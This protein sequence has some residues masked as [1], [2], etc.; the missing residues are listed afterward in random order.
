MSDD[1]WRD[2]TVLLTGASSGIG[3]AA[4]LLAATRGARVGLIARRADLLVETTSRIRASGGVADWIAADVCDLALLRAV[5]AELQARLGP[6]D[7][8]IAC[9]GI[10]KHTSAR[11]FDPAIANQVFAVNV[12]GVVN[13]IG[14][15]LPD[16]VAR[17]R[18]RIAVISSLAAKLPLPGSAAYSGSKAALDRFLDC[19]RVDLRRSNIR[20]TSLSPGFVDTAMLTEAER[21]TLKNMLSAERVAHRIL[22][23]IERGRAELGLPYWTWLQAWTVGR[24][25]GPLRRWICG[26]LEPMQEA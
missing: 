6:C 25:P 10:F 11:A 15:V 19:L 4:A 23:A 2:K 14:A 16:M 12:C 21:T 26:Q 3:R 1:F 18:G 17:D 20:I 9:A 8:L 13:A 5:V 22:H 24:L 7:A